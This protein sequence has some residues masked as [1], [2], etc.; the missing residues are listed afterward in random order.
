M[1]ILIIDIDSK[2]TNIALK[3][4]EMF[5]ELQGDE[6]F[7]NLP[8]MKGLCD[9]TYVSCVFDFNKHLCSEWEGIAEIGGSGYDLKKEL[10]PEIDC[11]K[12]KTNIGF[13]TRGCIRACEFC[14]VPK[15][16]GKIHIVGDIFDFWDGISKNITILD[17]N[18]LAEPNHFKFICKQ[19][20]DNNL[21]VDFNQGLDC[22][23]FTEDMAAELKTISREDIRFAFDHIS[24]YKNVVETCR[25]IEKFKLPHPRWYVYANEDFESAL[26]RLL[27]LKRLGQRTYVMRDRRITHLPKY[28]ALAHWGCVPQLFDKVDFYDYLV[29]YGTGIKSKVKELESVGLFS[30]LE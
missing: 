26:E 18:I 23:L 10:P 2:I 27:I 15:K 28:I 25:I 11:M 7:Y 21:T 22:R 24:V 12:P 3:K 29:N 17:N 8:M 19:I 1:K 13:T 14:I 5:H 30:G 20:R 6:I 9:K 16:E 4:I